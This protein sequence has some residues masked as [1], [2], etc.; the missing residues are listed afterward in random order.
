MRTSSMDNLRLPPNNGGSLNSS[1]RKRE[2]K[3]IMDE[4]QAI[5]KR[6][7][8]RKPNYHRRDF[9]NHAQRH[10]GYSKNIRERGVRLLPTLVDRAE[11][12]PERRGVAR[13]ASQPKLK[14]LE[15]KPSTNLKPAQIKRRKQRKQTKNPNQLSR[16]GHNID[17]TY[18]ILTV[19][20]FME[21]N[22]HVL[23]FSSYDMDGG[24]SLELEVP[25]DV[26]KKVAGKKLVNDRAA[27]GDAMCKRLRLVDGKLS[28][29]GAAGEEETVVLSMKLKLTKKLDAPANA[30]VHLFVGDKLISKTES[31]S[32]QEGET[33]F[34]AVFTLETKN[35]AQQLEVRVQNGDKFEASA[36]FTLNSLEFGPG[37]NLTLGDNYI[38]ELA[39]TQN[40]AEQSIDLTE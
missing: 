16:G 24:E 37:N 12:A 3:K 40:S 23:K 39:K 28:F 17:G 35:S 4:N 26:I 32:I 13:K 7:Q 29:D 33:P 2:L 5:L 34:E 27:L 14:P 10:N 38:L 9:Q 20:E 31:V 25:F 11:S 6:I 18:L 21:K 36:N 15:Q 30:S 22:R 19:E 8:E 1:V